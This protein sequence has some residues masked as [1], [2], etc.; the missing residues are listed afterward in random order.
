MTFHFEGLFQCDTSTSSPEQDGVLYSFCMNV[1]WCL[2]EETRMSPPWLCELR[3]PRKPGWLN[4]GWPSTERGLSWQRFRKWCLAL[5]IAVRRVLRAEQGEHPGSAGS[6]GGGLH[7]GELGGWPLLTVFVLP[8][9]WIGWPPLNSAH[10]VSKVMPGF[11]V[12]YLQNGVSIL[13]PHFSLVT[14]PTLEAMLT[15]DELLGLSIQFQTSPRKSW[16]WFEMETS[17]WGQ[18][19][20]L[21]Q[22]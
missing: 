22:L 10:W 5:P 4:G 18:I 9:C 2:R 1:S 21:F 15:G 11:P 8:M 14:P 12:L 17:C 7:W 13:V 20:A 16:V 6:Q 19:K 3:N